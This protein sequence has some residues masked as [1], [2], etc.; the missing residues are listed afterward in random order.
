MR[1]NVLLF[2]YLIYS[3]LAIVVGQN[4]SP[5]F[6]NHTNPKYFSYLLNSNKVDVD[7]LLNQPYTI[8][9]LALKSVENPLDSTI[10]FNK[11]FTTHLRKS[12][13]NDSEAGYFYFDIFA[14]TEFSLLENSFLDVYKIKPSVGYFF[15]N[16]SFF[17][18]VDADSRYAKDSLYFGTI[19]KTQSENFARASDAWVK[20]ENTYMRVLFGRLSKNYGL[21]YQK[22][23]L[24]SDNSFS[25][26]Q[27]S[28]DLFNKKLKYSY[29]FAR[30]EDMFGFDVRDTLEPASLKKRFFTFH[31]L[32]Y[33]ISK[34]LNVSVSESILFGG[35]DNVPM[36]QYLNPSNFFFLSKMSDRKSY[37]EPSANALLAFDVL[38]KPHSKVSLFG[39][40]LVDDIDFTKS[41]RDKYPDRLGFAA[42]LIVTDLFPLSSFDISYRRISNWTYNS[43]YTWGNYLYYGQSLGYPQHGCESIS[44]VFDYFA[45]SP[46]VF[47]SK[48]SYERS[49]VQ[50]LRSPFIAQKSNF[51][52]GDVEKFQKVEIALSW[53]SS[54]ALSVDIGAGV[55]QKMDKT[56][57][58]SNDVSFMLWSRVVFYNVLSRKL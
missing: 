23:L 11:N 37:E 20:Y 18:A 32:D 58:L 38:Y 15:K 51:P 9:E 49:R 52:I 42:N 4:N 29:S 45:W 24:W 57:F 50:D 41:L 1:T 22:G 48:Y 53:V 13:Q 47:S 35:N 8:R 2:F 34:K 5:F 56:P 12:H 14:K 40:L 55:I 21:P 16:F 10:K 27:F 3:T 44:L 7:F 19:G 28:F 54:Y 25:F 31:R 46:F 36:F 17:Y 6:Q 26:D 33:R 30:L 43:F 39:Q